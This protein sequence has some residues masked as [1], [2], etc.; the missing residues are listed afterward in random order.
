[1]ASRKKAKPYRTRILRL[2]VSPKSSRYP[3]VCH[4]IDDR[5]FLCGNCRKV[6]IDAKKDAVCI[7]CGVKVSMILTESVYIEE[8][9]RW[10]KRK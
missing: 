6:T 1:M 9:S 5:Q 10:R 3:I 8:W 2:C 7:S 4:M